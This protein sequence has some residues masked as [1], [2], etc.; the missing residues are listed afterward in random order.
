[1]YTYR[2]IIVWI[3]CRLDLIEWYLNLNSWDFMCVLVCVCG[4]SYIYIW[5]LNQMNTEKQL[6]HNTYDWKFVFESLKEKDAVIL[7]DVS[8]GFCI[9]VCTKAYEFH[10]CW[11]YTWFI[12][13][14]PL[15]MCV[16]SGPYSQ[17]FHDP[18]FH[19]F[20]WIFFN[21]T[22]EKIKSKNLPPLLYS[23]L[24]KPS[25]SSV[26]SLKYRT[27]SMQCKWEDNWIH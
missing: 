4:H 5:I 22:A 19:F 20:A 13:N 18:F 21:R 27:N 3:K 23:L 10:F 15:E 24:I 26:Y 25:H 7:R 14:K 11:R 17:R 2:I 8:V 6:V 9:S 12:L 16:Q 1:M